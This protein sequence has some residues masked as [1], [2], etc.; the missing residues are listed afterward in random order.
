MPRKR[1]VPAS[2]FVFRPDVNDSGSDFRIAKRM[3]SVWCGKVRK[4]DPRGMFKTHLSVA[5]FV[6]GKVE[7]PFRAEVFSMW[8]K[9]R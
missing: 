6:N 9:L 4:S 5:F 8:A 1:V 7:T 3:V 2:F